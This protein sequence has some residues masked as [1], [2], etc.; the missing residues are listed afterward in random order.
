MVQRLL[1]PIL[2]VSCIAAAKPFAILLQP[3]CGFCP[4]RIHKHPFPRCLTCLPA[5]PILYQGYP[6]HKRLS[7]QTACI[8][9][10]I[11]CPIILVVNTLGSGV[12]P[13]LNHV[14]VEKIPLVS[15]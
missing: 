1:H 13:Q 8:A 4:E 7:T 14:V 15:G 10:G 5:K 3:F 6:A 9:L 11:L 12:T 2:Q